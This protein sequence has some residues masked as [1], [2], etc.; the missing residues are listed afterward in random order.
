MENKGTSFHFKV[1][2]FS[3]MIYSCFLSRIIPRSLQDIEKG[4]HDDKKCKKYGADY[5]TKF[6]QELPDCQFTG[7]K[8]KI[9][10]LIRKVYIDADGSVTEVQLDFVFNSFEHKKARHNNKCIIN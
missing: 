7:N 5:K 10:K 9:Q 8:S 2:L 6:G 4:D 1:V 3:K